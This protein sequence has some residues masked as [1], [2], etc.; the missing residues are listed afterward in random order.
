M[1]ISK[2]AAILSAV[3]LSCLALA[4][5][6]AAQAWL[7]FEGQGSVQ[8]GYQ[9]LTADEIGLELGGQRVVARR[10]GAARS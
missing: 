10:R 5:S 1:R 6:V 3:L 4:K 8:I 2:M 7:P 9:T